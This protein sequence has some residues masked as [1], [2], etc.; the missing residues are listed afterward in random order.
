LMGKKPFDGA[1]Y[2]E[3]I[4]Q[5]LFE[6]PPDLR[7]LRP[8]L[9][10]NVA[11][12]V[13]RML[14]KN[15]DDRFPDLDA[16]ALAI[17]HPDKA[18]AERLR[19]EMM[20][21][22]KTGPRRT[23]RMSV[24]V[25]PIPA[26]KKPGAGTVRGAPAAPTAVV[27]PAPPAATVLEKRPLRERPKVSRPEAVSDGG[28]SKA[29]LWGAVAAVVV[30][31]GG[32]GLVKMF[33]SPDTPPTGTTVATSGGQPAAVPPITTPAPSES[34]TPPPPVGTKTETRPPAAE[35][36]AP[37]RVTVTDLPSNGVILLD[38]RRQ[39]GRQFSASPGKHQL[40]MQASGFETVTRSID[41]SAGEQLSVAF[42]RRELT[43]TTASAPAAARPV[44][45]KQAAAVQSGAAGGLATLQ[46]IVQ[47]PATLYVDGV[48]KGQQSRLQDK[49]MVPG[50]HTV[51]A[52]RDGFLT[53]D[54]VVTIL[55]G[56]TAQVRLTL[57]ARP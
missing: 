15:P 10:E 18:E 35:A 47:P 45:T 9:P 14:A 41:V 32:F 46:I 48:S 13:T 16:A 29:A 39:S 28:R 49:E 20:S 11:L 5:H 1:T 37:G 40:R 12:A 4:T 23:V 55:A 52:E 19:V 3:I 17:G 57:T 6:P 7:K 33:S 8:D 34:K 36:P 25:S 43:S 2:A 24:P 31:G 26:T 22:A 56:Q 54:T 50:T 44:G 21:L 27:P 53:K 30:L 42:E 51:R 38:G